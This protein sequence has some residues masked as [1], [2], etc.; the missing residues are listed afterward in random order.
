MKKASHYKGVQTTRRDQTVITSRSEPLEGIPQKRRM[1]H[2]TFR[3]SATCLQR[4]AASV[5]S[6]RLRDQAS[7]VP[8]NRAPSYSPRCYNSCYWNTRT[9]PSFFATPRLINA[10]SMRPLPATSAEASTRL[11]GEASAAGDCKQLPQLSCVPSINLS[12]T[13]KS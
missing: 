6:T 2:T 12:G 4:P 13:P 5:S 3:Y 11:Q 1:P 8:K 9:G 7:L 10:G